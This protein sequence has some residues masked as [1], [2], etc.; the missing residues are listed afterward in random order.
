MPESAFFQV[1]TLNN[2][3]LT[4]ADKSLLVK[5]CRGKSATGPGQQSGGAAI[6][7]KEAIAMLNIDYT[8]GGDE[9]PFS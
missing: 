4:D 5:L 3:A 9:D 1:L 2:I 8:D 6:N 7:F